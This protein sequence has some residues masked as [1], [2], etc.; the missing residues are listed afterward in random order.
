[1]RFR[2]SFPSL[3]N[4]KNRL[5][6]NRHKAEGGGADITGA[7]VDPPVDVDNSAVPGDIQEA[8]SSNQSEPNTADENEFD[9]W[10]STAS[11]TAK[12]FLRGVRGSA[13]TFPLLKSVVG[14][15]CF[16]LDNCEVW[17][18]SYIR[19]PQRSQVPWRM[20]A[21]KQAIESLIPRVIALDG[22]LCELVSEG[23]VKERGRRKKLEL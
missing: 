17:P 7:R 18:S 6:G 3:K 2:D 4:L 9:E 11:A 20:K 22:F 8:L 19:Y 21:N 1:M 14:G 15:L 23:D 12:S 5:T 13:D 10:M 16:I